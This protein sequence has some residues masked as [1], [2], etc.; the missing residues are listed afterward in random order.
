MSRAVLAAHG[1]DAVPTCTEPPELDLP[2]PPAPH[3]PPKPTKAQPAPVVGRTVCTDQRVA[4]VQF[5]VPSHKADGRSWDPRGGEPDLIYTI[6]VEGK[7]RYESKANTGLE[8]RDRPQDDI[9]VVPQQQLSV[10]LLDS[11]LQS[12]ETI[13]VFRTITPVDTSDALKVSVG[14]ATAWIKLECVEE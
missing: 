6:R 13:A 10:Q 11:D 2:K 4:W 5:S 8:W 1:L 12:A 3:D 14:A 7:S 9:R